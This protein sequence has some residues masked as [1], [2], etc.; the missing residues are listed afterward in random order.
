MASAASVGSALLC[1][2]LGTHVLQASANTFLG[3]DPSTTG[4]NSSKDD[5]LL[6]LEHVV[7]QGHRAAVEGRVELLREALQPTF[8]A[9]PRGHSDRLP[10]GA[11]R[12]LLHRLFVDRHGWFVRGLDSGGEAWNSSSPAEVF[13]NYDG[14]VHGFFEERLSSNG[15]SLDEVAVLAATLESFVHAETVERLSSAFWLEDL[16]EATRGTSEAQVLKAM[17]TYMLMYVLGLNHTNVSKTEVTANLEVIN[18]AYPHWEDTRKWMREVR[19]EVLAKLEPAASPTS[20]GTTTRVLEEIADRYGRWQ[21][22]ECQAIKSSLIKLQDGDTG[23]VRLDTFYSSALEGNWQFSESKAYLRQLGALDEMD[24]TRPSVMISNYVNAPSNCVSSSKFYSVCCINECETLLGS[25]ERQIAAPDAMPA[26]IIEIVSSMPSAT[27]QAPRS[28]P[29]TLAGRLEEIA[30]QHGGKVPLHGRLF[31]QWLHHAYPREC[32]YPQLSGTSKPASPEQWQEQTGQ[33]AVADEETMRW[34]I[35]EARLSSGSATA[36]AGPA[37]KAGENESALELPW[38]AE[39]E[40]FVTRPTL[41]EPQMPGGHH[42]VGLVLAAVAISMGLSLARTASVA[43]N[44]A[45]GPA[46][47]HCV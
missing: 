38:S 19:M 34:H 21:N 2:L 29:A 8:H 43:V 1:V 11:V 9:L 28:L 46:M 13:K 20:F 17:D 37:G 35:E 45:G 7:G 24:P 6:E 40:L 44:A 41:P 12:Y 23:R 16:S 30:V 14:Q 10:A 5:L 25:L 47:K 33:E 31:A 42:K 32:P 4:V 22:R 26:R 18:E 3:R 27:V 15:F 36:A 39:E